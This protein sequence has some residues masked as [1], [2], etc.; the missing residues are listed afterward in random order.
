MTLVRRYNMTKG[1]Y[2][3][4]Q[5]DR[6]MTKARETADENLRKFYINAAA[7]F[8]ARIEKMTLD[9]CQKQFLK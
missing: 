4:S 2:I 8:R 3:I 1:G 9:E 6:C 7:G 5:I